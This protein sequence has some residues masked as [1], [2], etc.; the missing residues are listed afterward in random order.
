VKS[1]CNKNLRTYIV[2]VGFC[3]LFVLQGYYYTHSSIAKF[4]SDPVFR[5]IV[6]TLCNLVF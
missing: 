3:C 6:R 2:V 1:F 4:C 5:Y